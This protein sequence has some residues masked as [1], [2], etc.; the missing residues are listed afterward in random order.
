MLC[1]KKFLSFCT[2]FLPRNRPERGTHQ[3]QDLSVPEFSPLAALHS[4][5]LNSE[6]SPDSRSLDFLKAAMLRNR[7]PSR[8]SFQSCP[9][10]SVTGS[11]D[12]VRAAGFSQLAVL[13]RAGHEF[14]MLE[15]WHRVLWRCEDAATVCLTLR[16]QTFCDLDLGAPGISD[17]NDSKA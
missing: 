7:S 11:S 4:H 14:D 1:R 17:V 15:D 10:W 13:L 9:E 8:T 5:F 2:N 3:I 12:A 16:R 6:P